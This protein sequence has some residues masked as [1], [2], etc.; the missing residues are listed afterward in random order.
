MFLH[1]DEIGWQLCGRELRPDP[2]GA[3][4][5]L[6]LKSVMCHEMHRVLARHAVHVHRL[7]ENR[8]ADRTQVPLELDEM[9]QWVATEKSLL[10]H[11]ALSVDGPPLYESSRGQ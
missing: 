2:L 11:H 7:V 6:L 9:H 1:S 4:L 10:D 8:V 3:R 5:A